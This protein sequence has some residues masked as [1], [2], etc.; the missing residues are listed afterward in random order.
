MLKYLALIFI[1]TGLASIHIVLTTG[2]LILW[3]IMPHFIYRYIKLWKYHGY[4]M[5]LLLGL[6]GTTVIVSVL[7]SPF[8]RA[9]VWVIIKVLLA[10]PK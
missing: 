5:P 1:L 9:G 2:L 4:S 3:I 6:S 10:V 8:V 7:L